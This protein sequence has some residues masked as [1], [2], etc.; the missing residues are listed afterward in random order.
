MRAQNGS[1]GIRTVSRPGNEANILPAT[2][3][4]EHYSDSQFMEILGSGNCETQFRLCVTESQVLRVK[5][6]LR[7]YDIIIIR[8]EQ[9]GCGRSTVLFSST[10]FRLTLQV[11]PYCALLPY[12]GLLFHGEVVWDEL[13][14]YI[15]MR[16]PVI[17]PVV[18]NRESLS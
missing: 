14:Q 13:A 3:T 10:H 6:H 16:A 9:T 2:T 11:L 18:P 4:N 12:F 1:A 15:S 17:T 7:E 8:E 5:L